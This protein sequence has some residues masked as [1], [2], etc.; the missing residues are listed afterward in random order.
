MTSWTE[1]LLCVCAHA[2]VTVLAAEPPMWRSGTEDDTQW[3]RE[4]CSSGNRMFGAISL[5][6]TGTNHHFVD[7]DPF[8]EPVK[9]SP[10]S[11]GWIARRFIAT[12]H[13]FHLLPNSSLFHARAGCLS[14]FLFCYFVPFSAANVWSTPVSHKN[15]H[16]HDSIHIFNAHIR[17]QFDLSFFH[18]FLFLSHVI[19]D[20]SFVFLLYSLHQSPS[21]SADPYNY[22]NSLRNERRYIA[23]SESKITY[24][25]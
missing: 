10:F 13:S 18:S 2:C 3:L 19:L 6:T 1:R 5:P 20:Y 24:F 8:P 15:T 17:V 4:N 16:A 23:T 9:Y 11:D 12:V 14:L 22:F 7:R 25:S 21:L